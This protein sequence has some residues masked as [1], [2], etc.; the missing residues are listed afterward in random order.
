MTART[1]WRHAAVCRQEDPELFFPTG[2][3]GPWVAQIDEAKAVC[4]RCPVIESC[5][6]WAMDT[7]EDSGVWGGLTDK[8][9]T[10]LRRRRKL[11]ADNPATGPRVLMATFA[12]AREAYDALTV[13][14][15]GHIEWTGGNEVKVD[16]VRRSA[17]QV[18]WRAT[19]DAAPVGQVLVDCDHPGCVEHLTDQ[20]IRDER[21]QQKKH[22][23]LKPP[24]CGTPTGYKTHRRR[25]E[26]ACARCQKAQS[27]KTYTVRTSG[28]TK[29]TTAA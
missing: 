7:R 23:W 24:K 15:D 1:D 4:R 8:E 12:V 26:T 16:G 11:R 10:N 3:T 9:R 5:L 6:Q 19:R 13:A 18:A 17:N 27:D 2:E 21:A 25:G 28:K 20:A 22:L 14:V 29:T